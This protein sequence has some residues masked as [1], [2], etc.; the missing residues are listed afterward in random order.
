MDSVR[1]RSV[2]V[3]FGFLVFVEATR[4]GTGGFIIPFVTLVLL[5]GPGGVPSVGDS[6]LSVEIV[7]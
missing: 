1:P 3:S 7:N 2:A 5:L 6:G 4:C